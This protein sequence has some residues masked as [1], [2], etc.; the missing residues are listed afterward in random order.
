M[1]RGP[2][3]SRLV[4]G[5]FSLYQGLES[6][7][8][9]QRADEQHERVMRAEAQAQRVR[10]AME[11]PQASELLGAGRLGNLADAKRDGLLD[12]SGL[13]L[14]KLDGQP[15]FYGGDMHLLNYGMTRSGKGRD[16]VLPN[17]AHVFNRS[18]VVNDI[19]DGENFYASADYRKS[20][21]HR[22]VTLNP[23][24]IH[25][26]GSFKLN[27]F[28]GIINAVQAGDSVIEDATQL[29]MSIVPP[30]KGDAAWVGQGAQ[31]I[32]ATWIEWAA[33]YRPEICTLSNLWR[34][35]FVNLED[36]LA[37][38]A[39][40]GHEGL[41]G[42]A[43]KIIEYRASETQW[44]AYQSELVNGVKSFR[45]DGK[46]APVTETSNFNPADMCSEKT[47]LYLMGDSNK[48]EACS[49]WLA[50][51]ISAVVNTCAKTA[52]PLPVTFIIDELANLPYMAVIPK[53]LTLYAGKGVQ[54]WGLCQGRASLRDKGYSDHTIQNFESQS[55]IL[56]GWLISEPDLL[57]DFETWSGKKAVATRGV[58]VGG[59]QVENAGFGVNEQARPVLQSED[60]M[61]IGEGWQLIRTGKE[62]GIKL[63]KAER[64][65]WFTVPRWQ[66]ALKDVR[67]VHHGPR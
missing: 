18:M 56:H 51:T 11:N 42:E 15:L 7:K 10:R 9:N 50:L 63:Y 26:A 45:P 14:G 53:A 29:A 22:I 27:P 32:I 58:N 34:F 24:D 57:R 20:R 25:G 47:T 12:P 35:V 31:E 41:E 13:F 55:G 54:L 6:I 28:Q 3:F 36:Q 43:D 19:K 4:G 65:P 37:T 66:A 48:L 17:L 39:S 40:C 5:A 21:R 33:R 52:G 30:T 67:E 1:A 2:S 23:F 59:G 64:V 44:T 16:I 38:I 61:A 49:K 8:A 62:G 60:I 46:I